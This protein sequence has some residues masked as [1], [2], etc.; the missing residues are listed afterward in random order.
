MGWLTIIDT[1]AA[2][3]VLAPTPNS[4]NVPL[5]EPDAES[6]H[7]SNAEPDREQAVEAPD[8]GNSK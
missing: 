8:K 3:R 1:S 6:L 2:T 5:L 4:H 7:E